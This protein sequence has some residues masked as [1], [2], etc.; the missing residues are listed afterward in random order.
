MNIAYLAP[1]LPSLSATFVYNEILQLE[2]LGDTVE[3]FSVRR[4]EAM[5]QELELD[6]L[7]KRVFVIY[8]QGKLAVFG[9]HLYLMAIKPMCY[10][11]SLAWLTKD[12][13]RVGLFSRNC[14]GLLYR[15]FYAASV[16]RRLIQKRCQHLHSHFAHVPADIAMY[17]SEMAGISFSI[18]AHANDI[19]ERAWLLPEKISRSRFFATISEFNKR[20]L[21]NLGGTESKIYIIRC[22][23]DFDHFVQKHS[24]GSSQPIKIGVICRLVEKKGIDTLIRAAA[25][26][27][28][29]ELSFELHIAG[30]GPLESMLRD[31]TRELGM[32]E[33]DVHFLGAMPHNEVSSFIRSLDMF[34]LPCRQDSNGDMDGIPVALME[35]MAIGVPVISTNLSGIPELVVDQE[36]GLLVKPGNEEELV[37]AMITLINDKNLKS[38]LITNAINKVKSEFSLLSNTLKLRELIQSLTK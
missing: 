16:A 34:V 33:E 21:V 35:A 28:K 3:A 24:S 27:K 14:F 23:I 19:F 13:A 9:S 31:L 32:T 5:A 10:A 4:P 6:G 25:G 7:K 8:E 1:E 2:K 36:T 38:R 29:R 12:L 20:F 30:S 22:G 15:F 18:T 17:A 26:L 37:T 11:K